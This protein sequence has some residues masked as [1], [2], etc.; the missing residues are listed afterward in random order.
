MKRNVLFILL[1]S[2]VMMAIGCSSTIIPCN[3]DDDCTF[4]EDHMMDMVCNKEMTAVDKCESMPSFDFGWLL[5]FLSSDIPFDIP[6]QDCSQYEGY[7][8]VCESD[9]DWDH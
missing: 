7:E 4:G 1:L 2:A 9:F 8:G 5:G 3:T 6:E